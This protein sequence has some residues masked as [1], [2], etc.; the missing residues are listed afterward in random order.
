M[1]RFTHRKAV[2]VLLVIG[3]LSPGFIAVSARA[4]GDVSDQQLLEDFIFY[5]NTAN[6]AMAEATATALLDRD[7]GP[8][9]FVG[10]VEDS[11]TMED[12][13][14]QAYLRGL[15]FSR[16]EGLSAR[17]WGQYEAGRRQRAR[18]PIEI[19]RNIFMLTKSPRQQLL[20]RDYLSQAGE[21]AVPQLLDVLL[22]KQD[23]A[24]EVEIQ[25]LLEAMGSQIVAPLSAALLQV[26]GVTQEVLARLL[27]RVG[28]EVAA[29]Y[30][31]ELRATTTNDDVR[32]AAS[33]ALQQLGFGAGRQ[34]AVSNMYRDLGER[35]Y[36]E[37]HSLTSFPNERH[38]LLWSYNPEYGLV[39][40][41]IQSEVFHEA[42]AMTLAARALEIN[43][44]DTAAAALWVAANFSRELD[45][46]QGYDNPV[47]PSSSRKGAMYYAVAAGPQI[48][49]SVLARA[50]DDR[51]TR[52]ARLSIESL[53]QSAGGSALVGSS[54]R[55]LVE[56]LAYPE[57]RVRYEA[58][59]AI[60]KAQP[61]GLFPGSEQVVPIL[62]GIIQ[63]AST[64]N[65]VV[66]AG[67]LER[68]QQ[69][70][71][72]LESMGY[73]VL[74]PVS[75]LGSAFR[76]IAEVSGVDVLV[77]DLTTDRTVATIAEVRST[78]RL[79]ATPILALMSGAGAALQQA[80]YE[81]DPLTSL[82]RS[83]LSKEQLEASVD[84]LVAQ[85]SGDP[86]SEG[87]AEAYAI[88]ALEV[89]RDLAIG[90]GSGGRGAFDIGDAAAPLEAALGESSGEVRQRVAEVLSYIGFQRAQVALMDAAMDE[91]GSAQQE[92]LIRVIDSAKRFGNLLD[93][94]HVRWIVETA[95]LGD[96][97]QATIAA[98]LMG[99][100]NLPN[101]EFV[102]LILGDGV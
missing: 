101:T 85:T 32:R 18:D 22:D 83:G 59:L 13:F 35:F 51:D 24:L 39:P 4:Q 70:R 53:A 40:M 46:E 74:P 1:V 45:Q 86:I 63:N 47:Y 14:E 73:T 52:L 90:T 80:A 5:V 25:R 54:G 72:V 66:V 87:E 58:A 67:D 27:G 9:R 78:A 99:A 30:L 102:P 28:Y 50:L 71:S 92:L 91:V 97:D 75:D 8:A 81:D 33:T 36:D 38:Q 42:R 11:A 82:S 7:L 56:A 57:R 19:S 95:Q 23:Q 94:R 12:R 55:S 79:R 68:Q 77:T 21:Y 61:R 2:A 41:A 64:R 65:A 98:A 43:G 88:S 16:L 26:D 48:M 100:L 93:A 6:L 29:P 20:A 89:L 10:L 84:Y 69:V 62:A 37:P 17:L 60:A 34:M 49:Q 15:R 44:S 96:N 31:A 76:S 3:F